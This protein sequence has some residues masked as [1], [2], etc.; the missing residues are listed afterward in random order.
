MEAGKEDTNAEAR[1]AKENFMEYYQTYE[2][3]QPDGLYKRR[4]QELKSSIISTDNYPDGLKREMDKLH[5]MD[6]NNVK[7]V[8]ATFL[9]K[10]AGD[11]ILSKLKTT[12]VAAQNCSED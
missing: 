2:E 3:S 4:L 5:E 1:K 12:I 6:L 8:K 10:G 9:C 11:P 7:L